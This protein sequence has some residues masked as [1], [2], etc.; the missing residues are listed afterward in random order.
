MRTEQ[1]LRVK[2]KDKELK[3]VDWYNEELDKFYDTDKDNK[4]FIY[5]IYYYDGENVI[6]V[7]WLKTEE[8]RERQ[9]KLYKRSD[10][11]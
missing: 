3:R 5:G 8:E 9:I 7:Q 6:D 2:I 1:I 11:R 10:E 4:G